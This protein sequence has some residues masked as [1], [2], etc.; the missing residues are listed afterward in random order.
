M[1]TAFSCIQA[2]YNSFSIYATPTTPG[3]CR[4]IA[5]VTTNRKD[6]PAS[7]R[8]ALSG[9]IMAS[10]PLPLPQSLALPTTSP[11]A[12][13]HCLLPPQCTQTLVLP[14]L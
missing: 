1:R 8:S 13:P 6:A 9:L 5:F 10:F 4:L 11:T 12:D 14:A 3:Q 2:T 7:L